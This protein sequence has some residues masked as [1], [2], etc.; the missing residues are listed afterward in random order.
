[1]G[2]GL[3]SIFYWLPPMIDGEGYYYNADYF[4][5]L[6]FLASMFI[7]GAGLK[8][9]SDAAISFQ[10]ERLMYATQLF[11]QGLNKDSEYGMKDALTKLGQFEEELK[12]S[13][14]KE[15][16]HLSSIVDPGFARQKNF[17]EEIISNRRPVPQ[18]P[19]YEKQSP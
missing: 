14:P 9:C 13:F 6:G 3:H 19:A 18:V 2:K 8:V 10:R 1:M 7:L 17:F 4:L 16:R 15:Y 5:G 12:N 11:L